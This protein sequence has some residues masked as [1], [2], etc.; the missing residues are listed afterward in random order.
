M[1]VGNGSE[2]FDVSPDRKEAWIGNADDGT[3]SIINLASKKV[4]QTIQ[5]NVRGVNRVRFTPDGKRILVSNLGGG[6]LV[7]FDAHTHKEIKRIPIGHG[8]AG[9]IVQPDGTRAFVA[10]SPDDYIAVIDLRNYKVVSKISA[11][12]EPDGLAWSIQ[13]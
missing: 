3:I 7:V 12:G 1:R 13:K 10:C 9:I 5:A 6:D 11:G 8:A 2:G 4:T